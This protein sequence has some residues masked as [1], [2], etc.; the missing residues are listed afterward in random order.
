MFRERI[1]CRLDGERAVEEDGKVWYV[2]EHL[3]VDD[4]PSR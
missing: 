2:R 4:V 3:P 1:L